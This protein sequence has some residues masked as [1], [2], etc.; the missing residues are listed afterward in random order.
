MEEL[1][2]VMSALGDEARMRTVAALGSAQGEEMCLCQIIPLVGLAPST[3]SRHLS[4]LAQAGLVKRRKQG[5]WHYYRLA[6][7]GAALPV[8]RVLRVVREA[9]AE[10]PTAAADRKQL[11]SIQKRGLDVLVSCYRS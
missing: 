3:V 6:Q 2:A 5:K 7:R 11:A 1:V 8:R 10:D 4:I 9:L